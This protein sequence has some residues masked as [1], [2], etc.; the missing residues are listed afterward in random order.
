[1]AILVTSKDSADG[2]IQAALQAT[3]QDAAKEFT[4]LQYEG[5]YPANGYGISEL[6]P[7]HVGIVQEFWQMSVT[8]SYADWINKNLAKTVYVI[9]TGVINLTPDPSTSQLSATAN[10]NDLPIINIESLYA[11]EYARGWFSAPFVTRPNNNITVQAIGRRA[12]TEQLGLLGYVVATKSY[13]IHRTP[14]TL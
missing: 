12:Q 4:P 1:M 10:G 7:R 11:T 8:T 9:A 5:A 2:P 13:L 6:M 14:N 3:I